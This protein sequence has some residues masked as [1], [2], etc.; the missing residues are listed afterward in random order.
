MGCEE[1]ISGVSE[2]TDEQN[3][4]V[5]NACL[6]G[7]GTTRGWFVGHFISP[8]TSLRCTEVVEVKW[9]VHPIGDAR[10]EMASGANTTTLSILVSGVFRVLFQDREVRLSAVGDYVLF[11]PGVP[12]GWIA[13][14][15]S[16]VMTV[17]WPSNRDDANERE[18]GEGS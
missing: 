2:H 10:P 14:A 16:V 13:D 9:G 7:T 15:D 6:D 1:D 5:G 4:V 17:R 18:L 3:I 8:P 12:H 11:P